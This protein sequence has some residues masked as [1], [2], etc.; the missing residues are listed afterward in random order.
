MKP[1]L[2]KTVVKT[3]YAITTLIKKNPP[4]S[5]PTP[6][7]TPSPYDISIVKNNAKKETEKK[8]KISFLLFLFPLKEN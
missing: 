5:C 7:K 1:H 8:R 6:D 2:I 3:K 4:V